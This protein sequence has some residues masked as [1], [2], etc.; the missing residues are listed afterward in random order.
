M[1]ETRRVVDIAYHPPKVTAEIGAHRQVRLAG[2]N[3]GCLL[4][5][6]VSVP[7]WESWESG[8]KLMGETVVSRLPFPT[9]HA[10]PNEKNQNQHQNQHFPE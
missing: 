9:T 10:G 2:A 6:G 7:G 4:I 1:R 5:Q 8:F 3:H